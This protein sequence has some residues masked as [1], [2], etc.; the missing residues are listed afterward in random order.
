MSHGQP[1]SLGNPLI[2]NSKHL[3]HSCVTEGNHGRFNRACELSVHFSL[4]VSPGRLSSSQINTPCSTKHLLLCQQMGAKPFQ[5][6]T[7]QQRGRRVRGAQGKRVSI[8]THQYP[9]RNHGF[10]YSVHQFFT[11]VKGI[12]THLTG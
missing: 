3:K 7:G 1:C 9:D 10:L 6:D 12:C 5:S 4:V 11:K 2:I 8:S